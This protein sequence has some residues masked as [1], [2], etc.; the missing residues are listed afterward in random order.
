ER[1]TAAFLCDIETGVREVF[2]DVARESSEAGAT[3]EEFAERV[4]CDVVEGAH[5]LALGLLSGCLTLCGPNT[6]PALR[7]WIEATAGP[8]LRPHPFAAEFPG[9]DALAIP[10]AEMPR[11]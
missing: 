3:F 10:F 1:V 8:E 9:W 11:R 5:T 7:Y 4:D 6:P 2:G